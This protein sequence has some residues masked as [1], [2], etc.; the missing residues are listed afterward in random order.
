MVDVVMNCAQIESS[1]MN[2]CA[3]YVDKSHA[4]LD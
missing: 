3:S 4:H 2:I 1:Q